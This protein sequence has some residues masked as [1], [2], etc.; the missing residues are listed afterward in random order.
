M[1]AVHTNAIGRRGGLVEYLD[2]RHGGAEENTIG[3]HLATQVARELRARCRTVGPANPNARTLTS[4]QGSP[5]RDLQDTFDYWTADDGA[6]PD[7]T[8]QW[9]RAL[10]AGGGALA[11]G[12]VFGL[13][14]IAAGAGRLWVTRQSVRR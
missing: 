1:L 8:D 2:L 10:A 9:P 7:H 6:G 12:V 13:L 14:F 3:E 5:V 4:I 11:V